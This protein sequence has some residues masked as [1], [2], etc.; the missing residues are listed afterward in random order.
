MFDVGSE[1]RWGVEVVEN[2]AETQQWTVHDRSVNSAVAKKNGKMG[3]MEME[4][5]GEFLGVG[6][7]RVFWIAETGE[8]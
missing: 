2:G 3:E 5:L 8:S 1:V 6:E 4:E 7:P